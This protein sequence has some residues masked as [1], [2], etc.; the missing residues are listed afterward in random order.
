MFVGELFVDPE[1][2]SPN[3]S[4][5]SSWIIRKQK[6]SRP[7]QEILPSFHCSGSTPLPS[8]SAVMI[9]VSLCSQEFPKIQELGEPIPAKSCA[10]NHRMRWDTTIKDAGN[11]DSL[12]EEQ[13][14][15]YFLH[16]TFWDL[17]KKK[18]GGMLLRNSSFMRN[19]FHGRKHR[20]KKNH[21][22]RTRKIRRK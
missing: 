11:E 5:R 3:C 1:S 17:K 13:I 15:S 14:L 16:V 4:S 12:E 7:K 2:G 9:S 10:Q 22:L 19:T 8:W 18:S 21:W 20:A 6:P